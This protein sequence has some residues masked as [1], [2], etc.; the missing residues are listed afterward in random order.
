MTDTFGYE[1]VGVRVPFSL[2]LFSVS[3]VLVL[4]L[5]P[6]VMWIAGRFGVLDHPGPRRIHQRPVPRLGGLAIAIATL[7]TVWIA[8]VIPG[9]AGRLEPPPM[10]GLTL[11]SV[12]ILL[13]GILDDTRGLP[14]WIKLVAQVIAALVLA[15]FGF[16]IPLLTNPLGGSIPSGWFN[17]PLTVLW[18][19][20]V[21]NAI[22]LLDGLDGLASGAVMIAAMTLWWVGRSH[23]DGWVMFMSAPLAGAT[24]GFLR[25]N[26]PPAR[27]FMGDTGSQFLGLTLAALSLLENRKGT[28]AI[29]LLF[30]LVALGIPLIDSIT[31]FFR[32]LS[33]GRPV[34]HGDTEH[35]HHRLLRIGLA[36]RS[37]LMVLWYLCFFLGVMAVVLAALPRLY[38]LFILALLVMGLYLAFRVLKFVDRGRGPGPGDTR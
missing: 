6:V 30:P 5:T 34:F 32:R 20:A 22:N 8:Y 15:E 17:L 36:P 9:P 26:Y 29:T 16:G 4:A 31:A 38:S 12:P 11:A 27:V 3:L 14:A 28:T 2:I 10:L 23:G 7:G 18:V 13:M 37:A 1:I 33:T 21:T 25:Y 35:F 24:L 19:V